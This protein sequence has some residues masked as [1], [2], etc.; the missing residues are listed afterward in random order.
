MFLLAISSLGVFGPLLAGWSAN[1]KYALMGAL[2]TTS[3]MI[4][5]EVFFSLLVLMVIF[6]SGSFNLTIIIE[7]QQA[8]WFIVCRGLCKNNLLY[9]KNLQF[10]NTFNFIR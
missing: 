6:L 3:Q 7:S 2:R 8:I 5:Y 4:S 1:S 9:A 10:G